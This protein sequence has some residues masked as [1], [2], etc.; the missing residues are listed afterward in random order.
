MCGRWREAFDRTLAPLV[1]S[2]ISAA[3]RPA[4]RSA[5][6]PRDS[7]A[8][9]APK[10][11]SVSNSDKGDVRPVAKLTTP[12]AIP[13]PMPVAFGS[14]PRKFSTLSGFR[15]GSVQP[16][17]RFFVPGRVRVFGFSIFRNS[18]R[19]TTQHSVKGVA[20]TQRCVDGV[21]SMTPISGEGVRAWSRDCIFGVRVIRLRRTSARPGNRVTSI[22]VCAGRRLYDL[23][24]IRID[25]MTA[26]RSEWIGGLRVAPAQRRIERG[27]RLGTGRRVVQ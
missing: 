17:P 11:P 6:A 8:P 9:P 1:A 12:R 19:P 7:T 26:I 22:G 23:K 4:S 13:E 3:P 14:M 5:V 25:S 21:N 16:V 2:T 24:S 15:R 27:F 18:P 20:P 10:V